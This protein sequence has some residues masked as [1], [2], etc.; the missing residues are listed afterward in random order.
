MRAGVVVSAAA[1]YA[2]FRWRPFRVEIR[3]DSMAPTLLPGDWALAVAS[4]R[5][6][7]GDVVVLEHPGRPGLEVVKRVTG[8]EGDLGPDGRILGRDELWVEGDNPARST[9]S[10]HYGSVDRG[11]VRARIRLVYWPA[12]RR[13]VLGR[14]ARA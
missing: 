4:V 14:D 12:S 10:R 6:R 2:I 11:S 1:A 8:V 13:R 3:G 7:R 9:D 5:P